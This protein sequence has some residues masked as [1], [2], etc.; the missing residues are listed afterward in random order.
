LSALI[1]A[2]SIGAAP[3]AWSQAW[4]PPKGEGDISFTYFNLYTA[5]HLTGDGHAFPAGK[6]RLTGVTQSIDYG[7]NDRLAFSF[8]LPYGFGK[9]VGTK[10]H[11]LPIDDGLYHG[12][13]QDFRLGMRYNVLARPLVL[14]PYVTSTFP[15]HE[16]LHF[17]H[18]AIGADM[19][20]V[21][22]GVAVG[23]RLDRWIPNTYLQGSYSYGIQEKVLNIRPNRSRF[24]LELGHFVSK[25]FTLRGLLSAQVTHS[26]LDFP[27]DFKPPL[28]ATNPIWYR[29]DQ[30]GRI[31][32]LYAGGGF[33]YALTP[34]LAIFANALR[35]AWGENGHKLNLGLTTGISWHFRMP[36]ARPQLALVQNQNDTQQSIWRDQSA[37]LVPAGCHH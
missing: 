35:T 31:D 28:N 11:A 29:H 23:K 14:T 13:L 4:T 8:G 30:L 32:Y 20:E 27:E 12:T 22:L 17:A 1:S 15:T 34:S 24:F 10:P 37:L 2:F 18:S 5:D 26:G 6:I 7:I 3:A 9:Y 33:D 16:Y 21:Q 19:W 36:W 25:R